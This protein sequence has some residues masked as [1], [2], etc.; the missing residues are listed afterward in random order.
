MTGEQRYRQIQLKARLIGQ[1]N[2]RAF[3]AGEIDVLPCWGDIERDLIIAEL[4]K[5]DGIRSREV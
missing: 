5:V 1:R 4:E 2:L 3:M